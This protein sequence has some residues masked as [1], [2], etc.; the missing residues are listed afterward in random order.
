M[1]RLTSFRH[2]TCQG[3]RMENTKE[4]FRGPTGFPATVARAM[5]ALLPKRM[6]LRFQDRRKSEIRAGLEEDP[7][8][9]RRKLAKFDADAR[10]AAGRKGDDHCEGGGRSN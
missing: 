8:F 7:A 10:V 9:K 2:V 1:I 4:Y 3:M 6:E 5:V